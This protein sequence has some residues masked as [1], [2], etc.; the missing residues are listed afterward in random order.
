MSPQARWC[1][2]IDRRELLIQLRLQGDQ[3]PVLAA[4]QRCAE[5]DLELPFSAHFNHS[6]EF[7]L[8]GFSR[9]GELERFRLPAP[10]PIAADQGRI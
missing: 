7:Q 6:L 9:G 1:G 10:G 5:A 3:R 4:L 2:A 8:S